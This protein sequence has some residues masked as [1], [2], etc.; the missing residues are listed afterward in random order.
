MLRE[1]RRK[2][3]QLTEREA[4]EILRRGEY[5]ILSTAGPEYPYGVPVNYV[6]IGRT[7]YIH[8]S[9]DAGQK[10]DNLKANGNV[11]FTVVGKTEVLAS[12]FAE[13][14]E[15]VI[16][17]GKARTADEKTKETALEAFL[18]KY[19]FAHKEA[20]VKYLHAA[21]EKVSVYCIDIE[22]IT[23]KARR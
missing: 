17:L 7:V 19:S 4:M 1:M 20:G 3:R 23:G 5:G 2:D 13:K 22:Q 16:V 11:C 14:Y 6:V 12:E 18:D 15:S 10:A 9:R 8:G 21:K